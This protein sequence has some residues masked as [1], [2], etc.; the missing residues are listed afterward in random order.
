MKNFMVCNCEKEDTV[1][2]K[3]NTPQEAK[4]KACKQK[5][6]NYNHCVAFSKSGKSFAKLI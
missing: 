3:A 4:E 6:W 1:I 2:V 5:D